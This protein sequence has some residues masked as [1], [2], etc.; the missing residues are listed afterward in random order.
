MKEQKNHSIL[1]EIFAILSV[2]IAVPLVVAMVVLIPAIVA[3]AAVGIPIFS[4]ATVVS[5]RF[6]IL[7]DYPIVT[8]LIMASPFI[9]LGMVA[10]FRFVPFGSVLIVVLA[11]VLLLPAWILS[12][13]FRVDVVRFMGMGFTLESL[14]DCFRDKKEPIRYTRTAWEAIEAERRI[15]N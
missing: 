2:V 6:L 9:V 11:I 1:Y 8:Y 13:I 5:Q 15:G 10:I 3:T 12:K 14:E 7:P 4:A